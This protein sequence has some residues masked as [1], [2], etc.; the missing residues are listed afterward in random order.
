MSDPVGSFISSGVQWLVNNS[1]QPPTSLP[2]NDPVSGDP[3][4]QTGLPGVYS[5]P[6]VS[7]SLDAGFNVTDTSGAIPGLV[8]ALSSLAGQNQQVDATLDPSAQPGATGSSLFDLLYGYGADPGQ[9]VDPSAGMGDGQC[10]D[11]SSGLGDFGSP[12][13]DSGGS[14]SASAS[15]SA[16][17]ESDF[18]TGADDAGGGSVED[19]SDETAGADA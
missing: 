19:A 14:G 17:A 12:L 15:D 2:F 18:T 6:L 3:P 5:I 8:G 13:E 9:C 16:L 4:M 11:P 10:G 1:G 7:G